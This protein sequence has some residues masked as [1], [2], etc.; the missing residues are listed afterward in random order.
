VL[1][2]Q[3]RGQKEIVIGNAQAWYYPDDKLLILWQCFLETH[4]RDLPLIQDSN[5]RQLWKS[6][7]RFLLSLFPNAARLATPFH[8]PLFDTD[9]YL[10]FLR[11]LDYE[12]VA[13]AAY[14]KAIEPQ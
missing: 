13:K 6:V 10:A 3:E 5:M 4:Y 14:G 7:T 12:P 2:A 8:D 11:S 9:E 1:A